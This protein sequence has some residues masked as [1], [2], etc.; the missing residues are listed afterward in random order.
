MKTITTMGLFRTSFYMGLVVLL[1]L[2]I[3][4]KKEIIKAKL[5]KEI[6]GQAAIWKKSGK[7]VDALKI[8]KST[9]QK[10]VKL[11]AK[12]LDDSTLKGLVTE[13]EKKK[14]RSG[15]IFI[16]FENGIKLGGYVKG[17]G[18]HPELNSGLYPIFMALENQSSDHPTGAR[19]ITALVQ[20]QKYSD[21]FLVPKDAVKSGNGG[22]FVWKIVNGH[23]NKVPV[24][25]GL[26]NFESVQITSGLLENDLMVIRGQSMLE[27]NDK[28]RIRHRME[29]HQQD[30]IW[31]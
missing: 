7:T 19:I 2:A 12:R 8:T 25:T 29:G 27:P 6:I 1:L 10:H 9:L 5:K 3:A 16:A 23:V 11:S 18:K 30:R 24:R 31:K 15:Q 17:V 20:T 22:L 28:V 14:I 21:V 13:R 4:G 26:E